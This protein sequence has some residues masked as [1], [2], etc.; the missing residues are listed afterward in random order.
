MKSLLAITETVAAVFLLLIALL[1]TANV[2]TREV[3]GVTIPDWFDGSRLLLGVA[4][5]WGIAVATYRGGHICVDMLWEHLGSAG[6]RRLDLVAAFICAA[7]LL[8]LAWMVW[9]KIGGVG[10]QATS[11]LRLPLVG[12]YVLAGAGVSCGALLACVR[13]FELATGRTGVCAGEQHGS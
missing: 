9:V 5:F 7:F 6:R 4:L 10:A 8:P 2:L 3:F 1:T 11:D 13:L 12:P